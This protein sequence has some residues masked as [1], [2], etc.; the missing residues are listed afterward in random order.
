VGMYDVA[1]RHGMTLGEMC[2]YVHAQHRMDRDALHVVTMQGWQREM[3]FDQTGLPWVLPS[4]NMPTLQTAQVYPG[5]CLLEGTLMSEGRGTTRPFE[6]FGMP[7]L[8]GAALA[9][10]VRI[11]GALLRP[12]QFVPT[13]HKH[14]GALCGGVQ[15]HVT[16]TTTFRSFDAYLRLIA[17]SRALMGDA[18]QWRTAAYEFVSDRPAID[19][20]T[21][22]AE[23]RTYVDAGVGLEVWLQA[24]LA[25]AARFA[26]ERVPFLLY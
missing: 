5:G 6:V 14:V 17:A 13:F 16:D 11:A 1:V 10:R 25:G 8:N 12:L 3:T 7:G 26:Q 23:Y 2:R 22:S 4:P 24:Q 20:L 21:G 19:L 18:M 9:A 15:V